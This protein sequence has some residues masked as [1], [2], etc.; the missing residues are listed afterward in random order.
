LRTWKLFSGPSCLLNLFAFDAI[1][2]FADA[3]SRRVLSSLRLAN[4]PAL[5]Q[6]PIL[7]ICLAT[8]LALFYYNSLGVVATVTSGRHA[9]DSWGFLGRWLQEHTEAGDVIATP[10]VGAIGYYCDR[11]IVDMLGIVDRVIA[12]ESRARPGTGPK[13]HDR[14]DSEYVLARRPQFIYLMSFATNER[15]FLREESW[16]PAI[17]DLKRHFPNTDYEYVLIGIGPHRYTLYKRPE[18]STLHP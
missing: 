15:E 8:F 7:M 2:V 16:I 1:G 17:E 6:V 3:A 18:A 12:H 10:V 5:A 14:Y 13:D 9:A 11:T 4:R